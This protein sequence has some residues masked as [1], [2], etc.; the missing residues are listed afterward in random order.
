[1]DSLDYLITENEIVAAAKKM[2]NN[3]SSFSD[4][5][6][7]KM[8][9]ASLQDMMLVYLKLFNSILISGTIPETWCRGLIATEQTFE[10][11]KNSLHAKDIARAPIP[12]VD[13]LLWTSNL[14]T[15]DFCSSERVIFTKKYFLLFASACFIQHNKVD[16]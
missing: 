9:K 15:I 7:N 11:T 12:D 13:F 6:K 10:I 14:L 8:I 3:K 2:K 16:N 4:K 1:M 5:I